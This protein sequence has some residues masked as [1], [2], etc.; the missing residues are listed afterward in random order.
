M[1]MSFYPIASWPVIAVLGAML[2]GLTVWLYRATLARRTGGW[3]WILLALRLAIV[4]TTLLALVRPSVIFIETKKQSA[5]LKVLIDQSRSM[6]VEDDVNGQSRWRALH[7]TLSESH[8]ALQSLEK[9]LQV[10]RLWFDEKLRDPGAATDQPSG[11]RTSLGDALRDAVPRTGERVAAVLLLSDGASNFGL[12]PATSAARALKD[13]SIPL[14]TVGFGKQAVGD[15]ARDIAFRSVS[16][17]PIVFE[18]NRLSV[19]GELDVR[20]FSN[21]SLSLRLLYDGQPVATRSIQTPPSDGQI[22]VTLEYVPNLPGEHKVALEVQPADATKSELVRTNNSIASFVTVLKGGLRVLYLDGGIESWE[23]KFIRWSLDKSPDI[24]V[25]FVAVLQSLEDK[26]SLFDGLLFDRQPYDVHLVR[27]V[28]AN[29]IP[30]AALARL[31]QSVGMGAGLAMLGGARSFGPGGFAR[32]PLADILPVVIHPGDPQIDRPIA[33]R[34]TAR[35]LAHYL[36]RLGD[37]AA[38]SQ[39]WSQLD[40]LAGAS[41][42]SEIK[43]AAS[44]LADASD[45][46]PLLVAHDVGQGRVIAFAGDTTWQWHMMPGE[47][48]LQHHRRFWRQ[49]VLWLAHKEESGSKRLRIDLAR[50]RVPARESLEVAAT[51]ED[52]HGQPIRDAEFDAVVIAPDGKELPFRLFAQ[53]GTGTGAFFETQAAGDYVLSVSAKRQ[54]AT[55]EGPVQSRFLVYDDDIEL[56]SPAADITL[57]RQIAEITG[58]EL[59][60]PERLPAFLRELAKKDLRL[61][62]ERMTA[63]RLWDN[64]PFLLTFIALLTLE[65]AFR[66]WKGLV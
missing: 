48:G 61:E 9:L 42:F 30:P 10:K 36:V 6:L 5:T 13:L 2:V 39:A 33:M 64:W 40:P 59:I 1:R 28:A 31:R 8:E 22:K 7:Q 54:G 41:T 65:W 17:G 14:Y 24:D 37:A 26:S 15:S 53:G 56:S 45:Q 21:Q 38:T 50:R 19:T 46:T 62:V 43:P 4:L 12:I 63:I 49:L 60:Q 35:G 16:A 51:I 52:E 20:G 66:K 58:G 44:V 47:V 57:L 3:R 18:K 34:P 29:H 27:D 11:L 23:A 55:L 32:T 25:D